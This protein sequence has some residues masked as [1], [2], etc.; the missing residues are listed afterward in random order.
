MSWMGTFNS[1]QIASTMP[2]LAVPSS[3]AK[4][5]SVTPTASVKYLAWVSP[6]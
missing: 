5:I 4:K 1:S 2:P 3:F 6:F